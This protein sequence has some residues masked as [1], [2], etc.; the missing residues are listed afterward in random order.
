[1]AGSD[2]L[3]NGIKSLST[4]AK[5]YFLTFIR[6]WAFEESFEFNKDEEIGLIGWI[7]WV[8]GFKLAIGSWRWSQMFE[9]I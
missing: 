8:N 5:K 6:F 3:K 7:D 4:K 1:M 2:R 9:I